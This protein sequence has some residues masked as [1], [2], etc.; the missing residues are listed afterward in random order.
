MFK[1]KFNIALHAI[2]RITEFE[3]NT[4][5]KNAIQESLP[6]LESAYD[7]LELLENLLNVSIH[8]D[9]NDLKKIEKVI[10]YAK[11]KMPKAIK[12]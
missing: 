6:L 8:T 2:E 3:V 7:L 1:E 5:Q 11:S 4:D 12:N 10:S 9:I